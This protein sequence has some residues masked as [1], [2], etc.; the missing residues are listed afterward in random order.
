LLPIAL[1][2]AL[3]M[4]FFYAIYGV[5]DPQAPYGGS[6]AGLLLQNI[7]RGTLGLLFDQKFG[8]LVY[9]PIY[10]FAACGF[11]LALQERE[12]R[13]PA[14]AA[15]GAAAAF[16]LST[17]RLFMWWGG[18][19]AP[20]RFLVP[21]VPLLAPLVAL[22][23][24]RAR[25]AV[26]R[27]AIVT[28]VIVGLTATALG[29]ALPNQR[30]LFSDPHGTAHLTDLVQGA[31]A[32][33]VTLPT[34]T[35]PNWAQPLVCLAVWL[36]AL[37]AAVAVATLVARQT[38]SRPVF[39]TAVAG[40][41]TLVLTAGALS[42]NIATSQ[43]QQISLRGQTDLLSAYDGPRLHLFEYRRLTWL[44]DSGLAGFMTVRVTNVQR[45]ETRGAVAGPLSLPAG[46]YLARVSPAS[47]IER[48]VHASVVLADRISLAARDGGSIGRVEIPFELPVDLDDV[49]I[50]VDSFGDESNLPRVEVLARR[51]VPRS[52]RP[53]DAIRTIDPIGGRPGALLIHTNDSTYPEGP[54]FWTKNTEQGTVL[55]APAGASSVA[56]RLHVG[57][58][59]DV[60]V[61]AA[62]EHTSFHMTPSEDREI[63]VRVPAGSSWVPLRVRAS[64]SFRPSETE[65]RSQD[66]RR[67]GCYV[68]LSL[69]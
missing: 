49:S 39:W 50:H 12:L 62:K 21:V 19:S 66:T 31:A 47:G 18:G 61:Q 13:V 51:I 2:L 4:Y 16:V 10:V 59:A 25:G 8:L 38:R 56:V 15:I 7:P 17:T 67:L 35:E 3:W 9:S 11:W 41:L 57:T 26:A 53:A 23:V 30:L 44:D 6:V 65:P 32:W 24:F 34:F 29:T 1:S 22:A 55:I 27:A 14:L 36:V 40:M 42:R 68:R 28:C 63:F 64:A 46:E 5:F 54:A 33:S 69:Q 37:A 20:A 43:R 58:V 60:D 48:N 45:T 52:D